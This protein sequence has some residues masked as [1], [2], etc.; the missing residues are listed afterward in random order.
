MY[1]LLQRFKFAGDKNYKSIP[2]ISFEKL[3]ITIGL[4]CDIGM[5]FDHSSC[6]WVT[7]PKEFQIQVR[8]FKGPYGINR[9]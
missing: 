2:K 3:A 7:T 4:G 9:R 1:V 5:H 6:K 8:S